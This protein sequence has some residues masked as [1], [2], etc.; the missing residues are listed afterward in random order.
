MGKTSILARLIEDIAAV[1]RF[2]PERDVLV[3]R[4]VGETLRA[5]RRTVADYRGSGG[6]LTELVGGHLEALDLLANHPDTDRLLTEFS[7]AALA[8]MEH[9][10]EVENIASATKTGPAN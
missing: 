6:A 10:K 7:D 4:V 9:M 1:S 3:P 5:L 8:F 2:F